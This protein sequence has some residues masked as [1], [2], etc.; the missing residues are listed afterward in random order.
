MRI[1]DD[2]ETAPPELTASVVTVGPGAC[3]GTVTRSVDGKCLKARQERERADADRDG[4]PQR[5][6]R[7]GLKPKALATIV[8]GG[9][10]D[11]SAAYNRARL[12]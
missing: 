12:P 5:A 6:R 4:V 11:T 3:V 2:L 10:L 8:G 1:L 7:S 9:Q